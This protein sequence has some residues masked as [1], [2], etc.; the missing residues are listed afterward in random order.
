M[1]DWFEI[2][3][4]AFWLTAGTMTFGFLAVVLKTALASKCDNLNLCYGCVKIHRRV[5]LETPVPTQQSQHTINEMH[6]T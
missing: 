2:F 5:E 1:S 3:N 6:S 4:A